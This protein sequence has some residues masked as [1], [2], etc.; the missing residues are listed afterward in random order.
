[1]EHLRRINLVLAKLQEHSLYVKH[2][3]CSFGEHYVAYL[4]HVIF[5]DGAVMD[6]Q[7]IQ[8]VLEWPML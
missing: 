8:T 6:A 3:K 4:G 5:A 2:S 1:V 7:K